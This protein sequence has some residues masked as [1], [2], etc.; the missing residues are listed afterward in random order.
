MF[1]YC[2]RYVYFPVS[3]SCGNSPI[4]V[5]IDIT[6]RLLE[7]RHSTIR[8]LVAAGKI[9]IWSHFYCETTLITRNYWC[10]MNIVATFSLVTV[11]KIQMFLKLSSKKQQ[12]M[13]KVLSLMCNK[14]WDRH[15]KFETS[16]LSCKKVYTEGKWN[17]YEFFRFFCAKIFEWILAR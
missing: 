7:I 8:W 9:L 5:P 13:I 3:F 15:K 16:I 17:S 10:G 14:L 1:D 2:N 4:S 12:Q 11:F 6:I